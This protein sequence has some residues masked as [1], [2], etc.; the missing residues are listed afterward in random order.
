MDRHRRRKKRTA[1]KIRRALVRRRADILDIERGAGRINESAY[2]IGRMVER[3]LVPMLVAAT[4]WPLRERVDGGNHTEHV[5]LRRIETA[6]RIVAYRE[7][8]QVAV[9][10]NDALLIQSILGDGKSYAV[11]AAAHETDTSKIRD[12]FCAALERLAD[13]WAGFGVPA[14]PAFAQS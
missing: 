12:L 11:I 1:K 7:Q 6:R 2:L 13:A 9:G 14:S 10:V 8:I 3:A 5:M 4:N